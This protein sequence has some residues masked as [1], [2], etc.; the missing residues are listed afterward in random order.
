MR[1]KTQIRG[2][3]I[4][5]SRNAGIPCICFIERVLRRTLVEIFDKWWFSNVWLLALKLQFLLV[6]KRENSLQK[7]ILHLCT[8]LSESVELC[9]GYLNFSITKFPL[10]VS[11]FQNVFWVSSFG[12]K[13]GWKKLINSALISLGQNLSNFFIGILVQTMTP[14]RHFEINWPL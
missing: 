14:K 8:I 10:K 5:K 11:Y 7:C 6:F 1:P 3:Q 12:P 4:V 9:I 2:S 13:Y